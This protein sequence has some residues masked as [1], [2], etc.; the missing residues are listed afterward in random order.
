VTF[1]EQEFRWDEDGYALSDKQQAEHS[2]TLTDAELAM[3]ALKGHRISN[4]SCGTC[5]FEVWKRERLEPLKKSIRDKFPKIV[6]E[7][8]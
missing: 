2:P 5:A 8:E 4:G 6:A 1:D 7:E 3:H